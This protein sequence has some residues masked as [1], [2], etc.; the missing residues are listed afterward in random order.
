MDLLLGEM[1]NSS[2]DRVAKGDI[3]YKAYSDEKQT[4]NAELSYILKT[5]KK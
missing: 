4:V 3:N 1:S 2:I 5:R